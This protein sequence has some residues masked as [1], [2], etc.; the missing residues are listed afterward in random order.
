MKKLFSLVLIVVLA[1][2]C[3]TGCGKTNKKAA[4]DSNKSIENEEE[5]NQPAEVISIEL[6]SYRAGTDL[7][8]EFFLK[9]IDRFNE[10]YKDVYEITAS[11]TGGGE[12]H[13]EKIKQLGLQGELPVVFQFSDFTY[14]EKNFFKKGVLYNLSDWLESNAEFKNVF[15]PEGIEYVTQEDGSIYALPLALIRATGMYYN[16]QTFTPSKMIRD[17]TWEELMTE[18]KDQNALYGFQTTEQ[19]WIL[20]LTTAAIMGR[21]AGGAEIMQ[22]GLEERV[23]DFNNDTWKEAFTTIKEL[24]DA[25]GWEDGIGKA[26]PDVENAFMNNIVS[27]M[28]NGQWVIN[29]LSIDKT[30]WGPDYDGT[31]VC[32][33]IFPGNVAIANPGVYD[34]YVSGTA[35]EDELKVAKAYLEFISSQDE[36]EAMAIAEGGTIPMTTPSQNFIDKV[37][38]NKVMSE[39]AATPNEDTIY[40]PY[41]HEVTTSASMDAF[42]ANLPAFLTGKMTVDDFCVALT[43][44]NE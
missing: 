12:E 25:A 31:K 14:A 36:L 42:S 21:L 33:D 29:G 22:A 4:D 15:L 7:P 34:W 39:F 41:F 35:T 28:P 18:M 44:A 5:T 30:N 9:Q 26:Y 40:V 17:M 38:E 37:A 23:K 16:T 20:N 1:F 2:S 24:Y 10:K 19:S 43:N 32:G 6:P 3:L 11:Y 8:S 13:N 27:A